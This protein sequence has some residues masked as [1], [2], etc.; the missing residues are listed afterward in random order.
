[1]PRAPITVK[2]IARVAGVSVATVS[3]A[4]NNPG[5]VNEKTAARVRAAAAD[6]NYIPSRAAGSLVSKRFKAIG[7]IMPTIENPIFAKALHALQAQLNEYG[8]NLLVAST[9]YDLDDEATA[10]QSLV[11]HGVDAIVL[12][13]GQRRPQV[14]D[15]LSRTGIPFVNTWV[16]DPDSPMP[17]IGLDNEAAMFR[18][19]TYLMDLGHREFAIISGVT[20]QNDR[21][22]Q[23]KAGALRALRERGIHLRP[24]RVIETPYTI[25]AGRSSM[26]AI[27]AQGG[28]APTA[29]MCGNDVL[30]FGAI[31]ECLAQGIEV[32]QQMSITGFDDFELS[33]H[34]IPALTTIRV[35]ATEMGVGAAEYLVAVLEDRP[36]TLHTEFEAELIV[37]GSAGPRPGS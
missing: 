28:P 27:L 8:Y 6:L 16:Y 17:C 21:A 34:M 19:A 18:M 29:V 20:E 10:L 1:M 9:N 14:M 32:P 26:R 35:P 15:L 30:A 4:L 36:A 23:R 5:R 13:G 31:Y 12:V 25:P 11:E 37:R 7:A 33:S 3:R 24:E 2:D 22:A